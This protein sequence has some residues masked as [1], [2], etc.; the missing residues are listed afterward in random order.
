MRS[1]QNDYSGFGSPSGGRLFPLATSSLMLD[2]FGRWDLSV[3]WETC[4]CFKS[5]VK[6]FNAK[7]IGIF[8][9]KL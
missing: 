4:S 5:A 7:V 2:K 8:G 1:A 9:S 6:F 3:N